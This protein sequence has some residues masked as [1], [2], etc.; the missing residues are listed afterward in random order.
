M[1]R[2]AGGEPLRGSP[3]TSQGDSPLADAYPQMN[4]HSRIG[5]RLVAEPATRSGA[6]S[7]REHDD[8]QTPEVPILQASKC[9][10]RPCLNAC[11][12]VIYRRGL[13]NVVRMWQTLVTSRRSTDP[14]IYR[15]RRMPRLK[16]RPSGRTP[17]GIF[18][19]H[20]GGP[21][22]SR[23]GPAH[24]PFPKSSIGGPPQFFGQIFLGKILEIKIVL[25]SIPEE[26]V[27][28]VGRSDSA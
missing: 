11:D 17:G 14:M 6:P 26:R 2:A 5:F 7:G 12:R 23:T 16:I 27:L 24:V 1:S 25:L 15:A 19:L 21:G 3:L 18:H 8:A 9:P 13:S 28:R 10:L 20:E 22:W 4:P